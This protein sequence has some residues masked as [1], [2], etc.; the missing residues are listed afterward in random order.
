MATVY[1]AED[2]RHHRP[3]A[4]KVL[5]AE[6]SA[7]LGPERFLKEIELTASLQ[8]PH[9]L[10]LFDSGNADGLLY[11]VMPFVEGETLRDRL[12]RETQLPVDEALGIAREVADALAYAHAKRVIHRDIKPENIL[13]QN[14]H[15]LVADFG[16]ALAVEQA[17]GGRMTQTG[18]SLGTPQYMAPEQAMGERMVDARADIYALGCV[19]YEMLA[20]EPP[21]TGPTAQAIVAKVMTAVP[22]PVTTYRKTVPP[23]VEEAVECALQKLPA[24]RFASAKEFA[25]ALEG[26]PAAMPSGA[27]RANRAAPPA[28]RWRTVLTHPLTW[29]LALI[30]AGSTTVAL[31]EHAAL[32]RTS[33][34][35]VGV[36]RFAVGLPEDYQPALWDAQG[37]DI[38]ISPDGSVLA[39]CI[40]DPQGAR[41]LYV[42]RVDALAGRVLP[43]TEGAYAPAF[44]PDGTTLLYWTAGRLLTIALDGGASHLVSEPGGVQAHTWSSADVIIYVAVGHPELMRIPPSGGNAEQA[45]QLDSAA[46]E[47]AQL[48]P[49][50]LPGGRYVLY[51]SWGSGGIEDQRIGVLDLASGVSTRLDVRGSSALG[52]LD[53]RLVYT[54]QAG[55]ILAVPVDLSS[56]ET[57][58]KPVPL[59]EGVAIGARGAGVAVLSESGTLAYAGAN[60]V[61]QL[62]LANATSETRVFDDDRVYSFPR[63]SPDGSQIAVSIAAGTSS[64]IWMGSVSTGN[65]VRLTSGGSVN[66][67]AEWSPDGR[68]ILFRTVRGANSS[69]WWQPADA[70]GPATAL[71]ASDSAEYFEGVMTPDGKNVIV[72]VDTTQSDVMVQG[73]DGGPSRALANSPAAEAQARPSPDGRWVAYVT[74]AGGV[75]QVVVASLDGR[76][77]RVQVSVRGGT[78][79]VWSRDGRR[80]FYRNEGRFKVADV[81]ADD[82]FHVI[83][84]SDFMNDSYQ[85][86]PAPHANYDVSPDGTRLLVLKGQPQ[87]LLVAHNWASEARARLATGP[88]RP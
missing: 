49:H 11:Y 35:G 24:D 67:R 56:G 2:V 23:Q 21:F 3:V 10:P 65:L 83:R 28:A 70:S 64:D 78:E 86:Q 54:D 73:V 38:A 68:R 13:L 88:A 45:T 75:P 31:G 14:G 26:T 80:I 9:I 7:V 59:A 72:Q 57:H 22:E 32:R 41:R 58:G 47:T 79:P 53:G 85:I 77:P 18:L 37:H 8:H 76:G 5:H 30:A 50:A 17:G 82:G 74:E 46:G 12:E 62:V 25:A 66:E 87:R 33:P 55:T 63:F 20:G 27:R 39:F 60:R 48:F 34:A 15:A 40:I 6:L 36:V 4:I 52:M 43:E 81:S 42:H 69:I 84:E 1:L 61:S 29:L 51:T 71:V 16:I 44:S 19:L